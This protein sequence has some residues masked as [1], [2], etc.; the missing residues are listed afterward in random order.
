M[1]I[2]DRIKRAR[3]RQGLSIPEAAARVG[4]H[5]SYWYQVERGKPRPGAEQLKRFAEALGCSVA[6]LAGEEVATPLTPAQKR[7]LGL[8]DL[9]PPARIPEAYAQVARL[10]AEEA[11]EDFPVPDDALAAVS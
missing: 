5:R 4:M 1:E 7:W 9:L 11:G 3:L 10:A 6:E 8:L 2:G